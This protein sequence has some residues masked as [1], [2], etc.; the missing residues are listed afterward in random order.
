[1]RLC[2]PGLSSAPLPPKW[3]MNGTG[4]IP[5]RETLPPTWPGTKRCWRPPQ[6]SVVRCC[7]AMPGRPP[8]PPSATFNGTPILPL[9][10][11]SAHSSVD[12]LEAAW[13]PTQRTGPTR[14]SHPHSTP[15]IRSQRSRA[16]VARTPGSNG[17]SP[18]VASRPSWHRAV[19]RPAL[20]SASWVQSGK[21]CYFRTARS[22]GPPS[23]ETN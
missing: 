7:A 17:P 3:A 21:T 19:I 22:P 10:L 2:D 23:A 6:S 11:H 13:F 16:T 4:W 8:R 20:D 15:G 1:M 9:G 5:Q 12:P 18:T 14:S